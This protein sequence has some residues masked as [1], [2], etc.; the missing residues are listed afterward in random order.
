MI[1]QVDGARIATPILVCIDCSG[2]ATR[3]QLSS[4]FKTP[5]WSISSSHAS[6]T[7]SPSGR[8]GRHSD[9]RHNC[10]KR[11][12]HYRHR[13]L[14][15]SASTGS[16]LAIEDTVVIIIGITR[17]PNTISVPILWYRIEY[18][19]A[20]IGIT[21]RQTIPVDV[22]VARITQSINI[23]LPWIGSSRQLSRPSTHRRYRH[24]RCTDLRCYCPSYRAV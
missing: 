10:R 13:G 4:R 3:L 11:N 14:P 23:Q 20:I 1:N 12:Q 19:I 17:V 8:I 6:P 7:P 18:D 21:I 22:A 16:I 2:L 5:S 9:A 24:P 15:M